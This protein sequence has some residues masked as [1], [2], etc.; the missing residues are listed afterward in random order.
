M[1]LQKLLDY[2]GDVETDLC[3]NFTVVQKTKEGIKTV[4][5]VPGG[6]D[7][8]VTSSNRNSNYHYSYLSHKINQNF[9][10]GYVKCMVEYYLETSVKEQFE[11]F[12]KGFFHVA[13]D[14]HIVHLLHPE[15]METII[16]GSSEELNFSELQSVT[17]YEGFNPESQQ[18][19]WFWEVVNELSYEDKKKFLAFSTGSDRVPI[20]GLK[21][22]SFIIQRNGNNQEQLPSASTCYNVLLLPEYSSKERLQKKFHYAIENGQ[23][24]GL[25]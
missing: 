7:L 13:G 9:L 18:I 3:L 4:E 11:S 25:R 12:E 15:E 5:L 14:P 2:N 20:G 1:S 17:R 19:K 22:I 23:G 21:K 24:F 6:N 8:P 16:C 10:L